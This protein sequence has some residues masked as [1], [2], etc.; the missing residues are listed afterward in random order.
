MTKDQPS[1]PTNRAFV[2]QL[3]ADAQPEQGDFKGRVEHIVS[4]QAVHFNSSEELLALMTRTL[5]AQ[6]L[7]EA[8][9]V[10]ET[11]G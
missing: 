8:V 7:A 5:A 1:L 11:E 4:G 3:H 2:V 6:Q 10:Q 9:S